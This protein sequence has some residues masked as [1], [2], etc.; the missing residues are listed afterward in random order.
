MCMFSQLQDLA[1]TMVELWCLMDT[2]VEEH[3][4][5]QNVTCNIAASVNEITQPNTLSLD[6]LEYVCIQT[7]SKVG[8]PVSVH[9]PLV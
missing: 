1:A 6:F 4:R 8:I 5:F 3:Q 9:V 2:P 7:S